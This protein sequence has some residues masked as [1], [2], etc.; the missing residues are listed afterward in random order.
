MNGK[1]WNLVKTKSD[2]PTDRLIDI[3]IPEGVMNALYIP[4]DSKVFISDNGNFTA[5][6]KLDNSEGGR[7]LQ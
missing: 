7:E 3:Q 2:N 4:I 5:K 6:L 1:V